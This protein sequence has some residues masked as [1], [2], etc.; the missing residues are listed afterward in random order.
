LPVILSQHE[1]SQLSDAASKLL[2]PILM[3]L[4]SAG[5]RRAELCQLKVTDIDKERMVIHIHQGQGDRDV[6]LS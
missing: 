1:V 3:T 5:M 6:D 4:Y 2:H